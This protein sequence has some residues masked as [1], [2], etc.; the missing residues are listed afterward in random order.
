MEAPASFPAV[1]I[2]EADNR[3]DQSRRTAGKVENAASL[4]Y[5]VNLF[6]NKTSGKKAEAKAIMGMVD[7][8]MANFGFSRTFLNQIPNLNNSS[9]YRLVA[10]YSGVAIPNDDGN[11]YIHSN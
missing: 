10:R 2:V 6:S 7:D 4:M 3:V 8:C 5:E 9:I 1:T 11:I